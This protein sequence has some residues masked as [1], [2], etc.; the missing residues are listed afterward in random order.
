MSAAVG[1][2][3][4]GEVPS[5]QT[6]A[7][8]AAVLRS[9]IA[10]GRLEP[11]AA[12]SVRTSWPNAFTRAGSGSRG[13]ADAGSGGLGDIRA[14]PRCRGQC[15]FGPGG[16]GDAGGAHCAGMPCAPHGVPL[17]ADSDLD[18]IREILQAYDTAPDA[19]S[20][21]TMNWQFH[22]ALYTPSD[23]TRLLDA[24]ERTSTASTLPPGDRSPHW[25]G[26][27]KPQREHWTLLKLME[28]KKI[29]QSVAL[30]EQHIRDTQRSIRAKMR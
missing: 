25:A 5:G 23:C 2:N 4:F 9:D 19:A 22:W 6:G 26:K 20:W 1:Q 16:P 29:N 27:D 7:S 11:G 15:R 8:L 17:A 14:K 10:E 21:S 12:R 3:T 18:A 28:E 24:I 13:L 30:L